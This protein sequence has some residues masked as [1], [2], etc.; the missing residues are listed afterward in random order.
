M[1][2]LYMTLYSHWK[3]RE[4]RRESMVPIALTHSAIGL[5]DMR[6]GNIEISIR[7]IISDTYGYISDCALVSY[8]VGALFLHFSCR[9]FSGGPAP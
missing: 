5:P 6:Y 8:R 4:R 7:V 1:N 9:Y 3:R 2:Q